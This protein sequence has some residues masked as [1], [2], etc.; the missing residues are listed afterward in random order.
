M[1]AKSLSRHTHLVD[2]IATDFIDLA[3]STLDRDT[4]QTPNNFLEYLYRWA[5]ESVT[6]LALDKRLGCLDSNLAHDSDQLKMIEAT[7]IGLQN[8]FELDMMHGLFQ[9]CPQLSRSYRSLSMNYDLIDQITRRHINQ[10]IGKSKTCHGGEEESSLIGLFIK[11]GCSEDEVRVMAMDMMMAGIDT[12]A[13]TVAWTLH[14]V[15][16]LLNSFRIF[17]PCMVLSVTFSLPASWLPTLWYRKNCTKRSFNCFL[18]EK[19]R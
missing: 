9:I 13:H 4:S 14:R 1:K 18:I 19:P 8:I 6:S 10:A 5:L 3:K 2:D 15:C 12:T 16:L 7:G 17:D 11:N